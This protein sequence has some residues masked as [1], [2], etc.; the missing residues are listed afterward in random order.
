MWRSYQADNKKKNVLLSL[1]R[2]TILKIAV[3]WLYHI[4]KKQLAF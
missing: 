2:D 3:F 4:E 1:T